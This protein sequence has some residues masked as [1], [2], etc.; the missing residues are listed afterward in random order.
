MS[1]TDPDDGTL[2]LEEGERV[3]AYI[4]ATV[5]VRVSVAAADL[6]DIK[7]EDV[8]EAVRDEPDIDDLVEWEIYDTEV[9][10]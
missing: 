1:W 5:T 3:R 10:D 7:D 8:M 9:E 6:D 4:L 2:R